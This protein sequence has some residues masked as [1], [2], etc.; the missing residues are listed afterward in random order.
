M[1]V[2]IHFT[3]AIKLLFASNQ[4]SEHY[5]FARYFVEH[6]LIA[7]QQ[8]T[9]SYLRSKF[10]SPRR[11]IQFPLKKGLM[12]Y[13]EANRVDR[14]NL[15]QLF[16]HSVDNRRSFYVLK[17]VYIQ[18]VMTG[19][20]TAQIVSQTDPIHILRLSCLRIYSFSPFNAGNLQDSKKKHTLAVPL[21]SSRT[22]H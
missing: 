14:E 15:M 16:T 17:H 20:Y 21:K 10:L 4:L 8:R 6:F 5:E 2:L 13:R 12:L 7:V 9:L 18:L 3:A 11:H 19:L 22:Q 1:H